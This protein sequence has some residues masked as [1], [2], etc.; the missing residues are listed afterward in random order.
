M[1]RNEAKG[2]EINCPDFEMCPICYKCRNYSPRMKK[3]V[4][5]CSDNICDTSKHRS[6]LVSKLIVPTEIIL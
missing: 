1:K 3:C 2:A 6:D 5:N 4:D